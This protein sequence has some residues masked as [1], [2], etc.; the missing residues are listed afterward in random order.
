M[1][2]RWSRT[3]VF[4]NAERGTKMKMQTVH[5]LGIVVATGALFGCAP[6]AVVRLTVSPTQLARLDPRVVAPVTATHDD[7]LRDLEQNAEHA[8]E[9]VAQAQAELAKA[10]TDTATP[11]RDVREAKLERARTELA[12]QQR[13]LDGLT[14]R[15]AAADAAYELAKATVL[16]HTGVDI[17]LDGYREQTAR[18]RAAILMEEREQL[19]ARTR[20]ERA[21]QHLNAI[22]A[23]YV[24]TVASSAMPGAR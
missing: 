17:D 4:A 15:H 23:R 10:T 3:L 18:V 14:W 7:A 21:D 16:W 6:S 22:K 5:I 1:K 12:W 20:F 13:L 19:A 24:Q 2:L 8:R 9:R 11:W